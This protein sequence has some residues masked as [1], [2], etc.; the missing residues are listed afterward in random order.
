MHYQRLSR[1]GD[2]GGAESKYIITKIPSHRGS[3]REGTRRA[4]STP[5]ELRQRKRDFDRQAQL[6]WYDNN[7]QKKID[8]NKKYIKENWERVRELSKARRDPFKDK[9]RSAVGNAVRA[10][11]FERKACYCGEAQTDFHH[12]NGYDEANW[13]VGEW[14]CRPHHAQLHKEIRREGIKVYVRGQD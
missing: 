14:L 3:R 11:K 8:A 4:R 1:Y 12:S 13:F 7:R 5:E 10:G 9:A 6:K 2:V